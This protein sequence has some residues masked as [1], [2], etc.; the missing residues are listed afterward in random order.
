MK[1]LFTLIFIFF[2][3]TIYALE[4][5]CLFEEV[6]QDG[7]VQNG[8]FI[9]KNNKTRYQYEDKNLYTII[10]AYKTM[11][12]I[13]NHNKTLINSNKTQRDLFENLTNIAGEFPNI[14]EEYQIEGYNLKFEKYKNNMF[15]KRIS[16]NS[17]INTNLSIYFNDCKNKEID[18]IHFWDNPFFDYRH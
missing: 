12:V 11:K 16:I 6:Y 15:L 17:D 13:H 3:N 2:F 14:N 1:Y 18:D 9:I 8:T 5:S 4:L 7:Q 10:Y